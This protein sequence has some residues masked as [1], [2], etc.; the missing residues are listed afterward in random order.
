[1]STL[2]RLKTTPARIAPLAALPLFH[3]LEGRKAVVV[4]ESQGASWKA[5]L[6]AA[7]GAKLL[8]LPRAWEPAD[9]E[10]AAVAVADIA[11]DDE[12]ARFVAAARISG[13]RFAVASK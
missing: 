13:V 1:M 10:G 4:G 6:L 5:E 9:L 2:R 7:A 8:V 3:K 11:D 12:A